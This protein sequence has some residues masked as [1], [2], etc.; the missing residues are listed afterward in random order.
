MARLTPTRSFVLVA[1]ALVTVAALLVGTGIAI[2]QTGGQTFTGCLKNGKLDG[3]AVGPEPASPCGDGA[4][5]V[6]WNSQGAAGADGNIWFS[7]ATP[8][9][10]TLGRD[11]DLYLLLTDSDGAEA[12]D[13]FTKQSGTWV[14]TATLRGPAGPEGPQGE[15]GPPGPAGD[16]AGARALRVDTFTDD[17]GFPRDQV[18][19]GAFQSY[20]EVTADEPGAWLVDMEYVYEMSSGA[21][22]IPVSQLTC[23]IVDGEGTEHFTRI[24]FGANEFD[25]GIEFE[26]R[27]LVVVTAT[28]TTLRFECR[29]EDTGEVTAG[30]SLLRA[31]LVA[32]LFEAGQYVP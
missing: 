15:T 9:S 7:G 29:V 16:D 21:G 26:L 28:P 14:T 32:I 25:V 1:A 20:L 8:P 23:R 31:D 3:V 22:V 10:P 5:E 18:P 4:T 27:P 30:A 12:G 24:V 11:G 19:V 13:V 6:S 2:G 17:P